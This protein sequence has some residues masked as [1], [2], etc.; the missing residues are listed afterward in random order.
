MNVPMPSCWKYSMVIA[1][2]LPPR[3][4]AN[5]TFDTLPGFALSPD[6]PYT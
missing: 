1:V 3:P 5:V 4:R 6:G 2:A